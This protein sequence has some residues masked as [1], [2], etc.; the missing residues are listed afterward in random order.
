MKYH[1]HSQTKLP[2]FGLLRFIHRRTIIVRLM[3]HVSDVMDKRKSFLADVSFD[4]NHVMQMAVEPNY[5]TCR[6]VTFLSCLFYKIYS[7]MTH[8][9]S[10]NE[11]RIKCKYKRWISF[12]WR[13]SK[14]KRNGLKK[15]LKSILKVLHYRKIKND[16]WM[17]VVID[18]KLRKTTK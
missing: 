13:S 4:W 1:L 18:G 3:L 5:Q 7:K 6:F 9:M 8:I 17:P 15:Q 14:Y 11:V 12:S 10:K 16:W 2:Y